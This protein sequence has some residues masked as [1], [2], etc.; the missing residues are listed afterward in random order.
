MSKLP[1][2]DYLYSWVMTIT[3]G[4]LTGKQ[5]SKDMIKQIEE[6]IIIEPGNFY[7]NYLNRVFLTYMQGSL[8]YLKENRN[9]RR[10]TER[11]NLLDIRKKQKI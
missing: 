8:F 5:G 3:P 10:Y 1:P 9:Y 4:T 6:E 11:K 7:K 2:R